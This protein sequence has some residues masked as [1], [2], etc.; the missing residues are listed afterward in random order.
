MPLSS[1]SKLLRVLETGEFRR[2][3]DVRDRTSSARVIAATNQDLRGL[4]EAKR[5]REDLFY[6][7]NVLTCELPPLREHIEDLELL[8]DHFLGHFCSKCGK[9]RIQLADD[10]LE[11][12]RAHAWPGNIRELRNVLERL[13]VLLSKD[14]VEASDLPLELHVRATAG[15]EPSAMASLQDVEREHILRVLRHVD[16]NKKQAA[17]ILGIDR[18][19]LYAKIKA[20][21]L[22]V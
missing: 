18:S 21:K 20:Y 16:G 7:I 15:G 3:G 10:A 14:T 19:T 1:Q 4:V 13:V 6:R 9:P 12:L 2:V 11:V 5:F 17:E 8:C 22:K